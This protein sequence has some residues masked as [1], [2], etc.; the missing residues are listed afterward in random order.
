MHTQKVAITIPHKLVKLVDDVRKKKGLSRSKF[1][2]MVLQ[3]RIMS[4]KNRQIKDAYDCIFSDEAIRE[5]QLLCANWFEGL[6]NNQG[7]EW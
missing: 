6:G 5:E 7:Q 2:S 3:E 4:E 1:I